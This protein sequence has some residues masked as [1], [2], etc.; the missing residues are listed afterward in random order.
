MGA[1]W[2]VEA[3][4]LPLTPEHG[5]PS[6][7]LQRPRALPPRPADSDGL[8]LPFSQNFKNKSRV[9]MGSPA[10][11]DGIE[12]FLRWHN[13]HQVKGSKRC[14]SSQPDLR[15]PCS[16]HVWYTFAPGLSSAACIF[17]L[18]GGYS[19]SK[20]P[21]G[22]SFYESFAR[23]AAAVCRDRQPPSAGGAP[24]WKP[25]LPRWTA[26]PPL[27]SCATRTAPPAELLAEARALAALCH[28]RGVPF[29]VDDDVEVALASGADGVHVG[30]SDM[31]ARR[32][33]P[34]W[35]RTKF[36]AYQRITPP[37]PWR[38]RRTVRTT[39]AVARRL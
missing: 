23:T 35:G 24:C 9:P 21:Q 28:T 11:K 15:L 5:F 19:G 38:H 14:A 26:G 20:Q 17:A 31:A 32:A 10:K 25:S 8:S 12:S 36:L 4:W 37:K 30:Q 13:P 34:C 22:G 18:A 7:T 27:C 3:H 29:V 6:R 39:L 2:S 33:R 1:W 16:Y